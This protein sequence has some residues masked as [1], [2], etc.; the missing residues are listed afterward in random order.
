MERVDEMNAPPVI[1]RY[2]FVPTVTF[3]YDGVTRDWPVI[4]VKHADADHLKF[5]DQHYHFDFRFFTKRIWDKFRDH[6]RDW[7]ST[8]ITEVEAPHARV[9][10]EFHYKTSEDPNLPDTVVYKKLRCRRDFSFLTIGRL[11]GFAD[12]HNA[13]SGRPAIKTNNGFV[14]PHRHAPL[15]GLK[16]DD[17]GVVQC[18]LHGLCFNSITGEAVAQ[19]SKE[20]LTEVAAFDFLRERGR[21]PRSLGGPE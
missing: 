6:S 8:F 12:L 3:P 7:P 11:Q 5:P 2:Y 21:L 10:S 17:A 9:L 20:K 4:G 14:C 18:P 1:G 19:P 15:S 16:P 13:Y